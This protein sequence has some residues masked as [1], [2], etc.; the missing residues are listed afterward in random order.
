[1]LMLEV[2]AREARVTEAAARVLCN[3]RA[4]V[5]DVA[6]LGL[7]SRSSSHAL[8]RRD[9]HYTI[10][11]SAEL[12]RQHVRLHAAQPHTLAFPALLLCRPL[13]TSSVEWRCS[14]QSRPCSLLC[15]L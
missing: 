12:R 14:A 2:L 3:G 8:A 9:R 1:M 15:L 11:H 5:V 13:D 4:H 10:A 7:I 6:H